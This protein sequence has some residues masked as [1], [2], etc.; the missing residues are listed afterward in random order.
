MLKNTKAY[1]ART[2]VVAIGAVLTTAGFIAGSLWMVLTGAVLAVCAF[3]SI[4]VAIVRDRTM[5]EADTKDLNTAF[6][7]GFM[8]RLWLLAA[9][10]ILTSIAIE[11]GSLTAALGGLVF[12]LAG[13][14][15]LLKL[16]LTRG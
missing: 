1:W 5:L 10:L 3:I 16:F 14:G 12:M 13:T 11:T 7:P 9:G 4:I 15:L 2:A 8:P 6:K